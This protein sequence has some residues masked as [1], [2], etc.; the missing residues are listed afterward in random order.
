MRRSS[1]PPTSA[2]CSARIILCCRITSTFPSGITDERHRLSQA[3][4]RFAGPS[5]QTRDGNADPKFGPTKA[6]D[7]ELEIGFFVSPGN[8][9]GERVP[10]GE[11]GDHIFGICL[12]NDWSARDVQAWE[13]QPLGPFLAKSFSTSLS[14]WVVTMEALAP[15]R[16]TAFTRAAGRSGASAVSARRRRSGARRA[17]CDARSVPA[18]GENARAGNRSRDLEPQQWPRS[19]LDHGADAYASCQQR[20]QS[21]GGRSAGER[22]CFGAG[23]PGRECKRARMSAGTDFARRKSDY[24]AVR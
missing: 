13:Y 10:I 22:N 2:N 24:V 5:G 18:I 20:L 16:T 3:E 23:C 4:P 15:F 19:L 1:T 8:G 11:A 9:L 12:L 14:P 6:L 17:R 7:Y 21:A